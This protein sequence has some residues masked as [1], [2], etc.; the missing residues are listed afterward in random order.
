MELSYTRGER[1]LRCRSFTVKL[2]IYGFAIALTLLSV[3]ISNR[4]HQLGSQQGTVQAQYHEAR[5]NQEAS[6]IY[7]ILQSN[8]MA[9]AKGSVW[10]VVRTILEES[11]KHSLDPA[12]VL[13]IMWVESRFRHRAVS[14]SGARGLMQL[15]P[16][17]ASAFAEEA[18]LEKWDGPKALEN[19][20]INI[21]L[22]VY[23]LAYLHQMFKDMKLALTAYFLGP[24]EVQSRLLKN[25][26]V[27]LEYAR[28][29]IAVAQ[30]YRRQ[31]RSV[32]E[33]EKSNHPNLP[34]AGVG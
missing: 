33:R 13:A 2:S 4:G 11:R 5:G 32:R 20:V 1:T 19:P 28:N 27:S 31:I 29:V 18:G 12:V 22:G 26:V 6:A 9:L 34:P 16:F 24:T 21:K 23:Y 17:V 25:K 14:M 8:D 30:N 15:R 7:S 3:P 10:A